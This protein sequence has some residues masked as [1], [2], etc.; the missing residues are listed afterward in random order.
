MENDPDSRVGYIY[1]I[2]E[3]EFLNTNTPVFKFGMTK[4]SPD[5]RIRRVQKYKK[6]SEIVMI[7]EVY[8]SSYTHRIESEIKKEFERWFKPHSDGHE[9]FIGCRLQMTKL[10]VD[11]VYKYNYNACT[12]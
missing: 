5:S 7:M 9:Y 2:R 3:R 11:I 1:L 6:G 10:I 8:D 4:Q 12:I